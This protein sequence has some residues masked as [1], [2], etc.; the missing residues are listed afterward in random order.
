MQPA[1]ARQHSPQVE[2]A[3]PDQVAGLQELPQQGHDLQALTQAAQV[4]GGAVHPCRPE[5][6]HLVLP[7]RWN[8]PHLK[9]PQQPHDQFSTTALAQSAHT[10]DT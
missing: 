4:D 1:V 5:L 10:K 6:L 9:A 2:E 7:A 3:V 8:S